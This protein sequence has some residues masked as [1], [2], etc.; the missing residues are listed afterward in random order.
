LR[1][2]LKRRMPVIVFQGTADP[3]LN[4]ANADQVITQWART[5]DYLDGNMEGK[6]ALD[7]AGELING[8]SRVD[9]VFR[10]ASMRTALAGC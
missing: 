5:N 3:Y 8:G 6:S 9:I 1:E 10:S 4:P 7:Q 2:K